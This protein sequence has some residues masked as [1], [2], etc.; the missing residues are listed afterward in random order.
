MALSLP[1]RRDTSLQLFCK[2]REAGAAL[3]D[4]SPNSAQM[5]QPH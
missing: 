2:Q 5:D 3:S 1:T 4:E